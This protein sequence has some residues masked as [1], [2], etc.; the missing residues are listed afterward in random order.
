MMVETPTTSAL[1]TRFR[2]QWATM[3]A[4]GQA[5]WVGMPAALQRAWEHLGDQVR[6]AFNLPTRDEL[7]R[8]TARLDEL[9]ARL[10]AVT[11]PVPEKEKRSGGARKRA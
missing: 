7:A 10:G 9:D 5:Q 6:A 1:A 4:R 3:M 11:A 2:N 8:L